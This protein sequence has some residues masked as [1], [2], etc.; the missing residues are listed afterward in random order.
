L[1]LLEFRDQEAEHKAL[2]GFFRAEVLEPLRVEVFLVRE[3]EEVLKARTRIGSVLVFV[4]GRTRFYKGFLVVEINLEVPPA[5]SICFKFG[6][7]VFEIF[8]V[9]IPIDVTI[10]SLLEIAL[11]VLSILSILTRV[12]H[13]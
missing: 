7:V 9:I 13:I 11:F 5:E 1:A 4:I 2:S 6:F 8:E 12:L 3:E 10:V